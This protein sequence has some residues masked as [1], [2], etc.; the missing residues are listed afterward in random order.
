VTPPAPAPSSLEAL[1]SSLLDVA[2]AAFAVTSMLSVGLGHRLRDLLAPLR[3]GRAV[4]R[5]LAANFVLVPLLGAALAR[6]LGLAPALRDGLILVSMAA[7]APFLVK[8]TEHA[9]HD[10][11]RSATLLLLLL[12]ATVVFMPVFVPVAA[13]GTTVSARAIAEPLVL[14]LLVPMAI[15]LAVRERHARA[16]ERLRPL[17]S[18]AS[19]AALATLV[20]LTVVLNARRIL[21]LFGTGAILAVI[22]LV[23]GAFGI[24]WA[25]GGEDVQNRGILGLGTAQRNIAAATVV[26]DRAFGD[27]ETLVMVVVSSLVGLAL[28]FPTAAALR[29]NAARHAVPARR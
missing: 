18:R 25:L 17:L 13:P 21:E 16:G 11:G 28:L 5:A 7:G 24:G 23:A 22:L 10:V 20:A 6:L 4:L 8:L 3:S 14:T 12:P 29:R 1:L 15:G 9:E 26:A 19:T 27:R 2:V